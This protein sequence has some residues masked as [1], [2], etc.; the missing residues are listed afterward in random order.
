M[1]T[2][3]TENSSG[4]GGGSSS[5]KDPKGLLANG[6]LFLPPSFYNLQ[7]AGFGYGNLDDQMKDAARQWAVGAGGFQGNNVPRF[8][9]VA[10]SDPHGTFGGGASTMPAN[11]GGGLLGMSAYSGGFNPFTGRGNGPPFAPPGGGGPGGPPGAPPPAG[12]PPAPGTPGIPAGPP[13]Q[14]GQPAVQPP[15]YMPPGMPPPTQAPLPGTGMPPRTP[16]PTQPPVSGIGG[17]HFGGLLGGS[18]PPKSGL[19]PTQGGPAGLL[20]P[21]GQPMV[22]SN[23]ANY[24]PSDLKVPGA[25]ANTSPEA[26]AQYF[27]SLPEDQKGDY[28]NAISQYGLTKG[29]NLGG[30]LDAALRSTMGADAFRNWLTTMDTKQGSG[31][32]GT[33]GLPSW[34]VQGLGG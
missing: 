2:N 33:A 16:N 27:M 32:K 18:P 24:K 14:P 13:G 12:G 30:A 6:A 22:Y 19:Q 4:G 21:Q 29:Q 1:A 31:I 28:F 11:V 23:Q 17:G 26:M 20:A 15:R 34:L 10:G 5:A 9:G 7:N 8:N 25:D 3:T